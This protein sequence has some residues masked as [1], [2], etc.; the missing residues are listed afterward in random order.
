MC[1]PLAISQQVP[2]VV[3]F[4]LLLYYAECF[5][6]CWEPLTPIFPWIIW[7]WRKQRID[8]K[9]LC[10]THCREA[11]G[12]GAS[13]LGI[14][15]PD[16]L[17]SVC[18]SGPSVVRRMHKQTEKGHFETVQVK[19]TEEGANVGITKARLL[20]GTTKQNGH[21]ALR[22]WGH[23]CFGSEKLSV[24]VMDDGMDLCSPVTRKK[25]L[26]YVMSS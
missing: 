10:S 8:L 14:C 12:L 3:E 1:L 13:R 16:H 18:A 4:L 20:M 9:P 7:A 2:Q 21:P 26:C 6:S 15:P 22:L 19:D 11:C 25:T 24:C 5:S 23:S 17:E